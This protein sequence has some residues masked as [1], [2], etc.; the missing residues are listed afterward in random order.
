MPSTP[1]LWLS[2]ELQRLQGAQSVPGTPR[3]PTRRR[4]FFGRSKSI[5][6]ERDALASHVQQ[7]EE[8]LQ[9][10][11]EKCV[12]LERAKVKV[13]GQLA[14]AVQDARAARSEKA[15][16]ESR[17]SYAISHLHYYSKVFLVSE[18][19]TLSCLSVSLTSCGKRTRRG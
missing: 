11:T 12:G 18:L 2:Q 8:Q 5:A 6:L 14:E 17:V 3:A 13:E 4:S 19:L 7:L 16:V 10:M 1:L 15:A 9:K